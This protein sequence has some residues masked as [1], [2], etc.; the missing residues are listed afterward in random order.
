MDNL[1]IYNKGKVVPKEAQKPFNNGSFSGTDI[2]PM[3]RIKTLTEIFGPVGLGWTYSLEEHWNETINNEVHTHVRINLYVKYNG[4]WSKPIP[5]IGGNKSLQQFKN[6]PKASDEGYKMALTDA[7][8]VACKALG[9]GADVYYQNDATK[10]TEHYIKETPPTDVTLED[11]IEA[12]KKA[13]D[14]T[15]LTALWKK[16][17]KQFGQDAQFKKIF[18]EHPN[19][20]VGK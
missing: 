3:W 5:G 19:K 16:Y 12:V 1:E 10:Y 15:E 6:G 17:S 9:I 18:Q 7:I 2:N 20:N 8:S 13:K 14:Y 11:A 4:E